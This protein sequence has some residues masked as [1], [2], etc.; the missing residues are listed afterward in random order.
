VAGGGG[1]RRTAV[2]QVYNPMGREATNKR[3][4]ACAVTLNWRPTGRVRAGRRRVK[5]PHE[6]SAGCD[7]RPWWHESVNGFRRRFAC[8]GGY[9]RELQRQAR[10][11]AKTTV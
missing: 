10:P 6:V 1:R 8:A 4:G 11:E 2:G 5:Q 3:G 7:C 9:A